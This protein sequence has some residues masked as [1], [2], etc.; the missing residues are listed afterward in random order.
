MLAL[1]DNDPNVLNWK[2]LARQMPRPR[3]IVALS[4]HW[5]VGENCVT[6]QENP[7]TI[8]DFE[9]FPQALFDVQYPAP[10]SPELA[11]NIS[12]LV[13]EANNGGKPRMDSDSWGLDHGTWAVLRHMYP[14]ADIPVVQ[15]SLDA[16]KPQSYHYKIGRSLSK[17]RD[18]GVLI[19]GSGNLVH[20]FGHLSND[21]VPPKWASDFVNW[22]RDVSQDPSI[23]R[24]DV[25]AYPVVHWQKHESGTKVQNGPDHLL[26][27]L[28]ILGA[29]AQGESI[30]W[31]GERWDMGS[32]S[33]ACFQVGEVLV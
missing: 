3:A 22:I 17:L 9:G 12:A 20:H 25:K 13:A 27:S 1:M 19:L 2:K 11:Q 26:P 33:M 18:E 15:L 23:D 21:P 24:N 10:G 31:S 4:A 16:R 29:A 14:E 8:H 6:A 32:L 30:T 5:Y 7:R 28:Y